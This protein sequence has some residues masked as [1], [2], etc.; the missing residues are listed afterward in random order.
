M[1]DFL[2]DLENIS[3]AAVKR[4]TNWVRSL[5]RLPQPGRG[6]TINKREIVMG[7]WLYDIVH[8]GPSPANDWMKREVE[9]SVDGVVRE[10]LEVSPKD[11]LVSPD[12]WFD[13]GTT[14]DLRWID[15]DDANP[16]NT[17]TP[18]EAFEFQVNDDVPPPQP[19]MG[20]VQNKREAP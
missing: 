6:F 3:Q 13:E 11:A 16:A 14:V 10:L 19:G 9:I 5:R 17:S 12:V 20:G 1:A 4:F 2:N 8:P 15:S 7:K 18:S